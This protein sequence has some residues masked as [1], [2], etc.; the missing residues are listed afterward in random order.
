MANQK[1]DTSIDDLLKIIAQSG[2]KEHFEKLY[3]ALIKTIPVHTAR[4][5]TMS[6]TNLEKTF[7]IKR[8]NYS[9][10]ATITSSD[11]NN[12]YTAKVL[13]VDGESHVREGD[14]LTISKRELELTGRPTSSKL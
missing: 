4:R 10:I 7:R 3:K 2:N 9:V 11:G 1:A 12:L 8:I 14:N 13:S 5:T 6:D